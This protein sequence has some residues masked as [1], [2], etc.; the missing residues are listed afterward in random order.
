MQRGLSGS[1]E[2]I[3]VRNRNS[4]LQPVERPTSPI[5]CYLLVTCLPG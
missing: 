1:P 4:S 5:E 3:P 2:A